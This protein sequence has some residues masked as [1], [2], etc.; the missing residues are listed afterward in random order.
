MKPENDP[1]A[2][3]FNRIMQS[4]LFRTDG[5]AIDLPESLAALGNAVRDSETDESTW[6]LGGCD[7]CTLG[8]LIV[9]SYWAL[10]KWHGGQSSPEYAAMCALGRVFSP[11]PCASG[12][13]PESDESDAYDAVCAWFESRTR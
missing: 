9:G 6:S 13:E 2:A 8:G 4:S 3:A 1:I 12:P 7:A 11:G 10:T 5:P